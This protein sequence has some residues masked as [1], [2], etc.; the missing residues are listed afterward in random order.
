MGPVIAAGVV[1]LAM[2]GISLWGAKALPPGALLPLHHGIGGYGNWKP[3]AIG[4][5]TYPV[6][7]L[8]LGG[9]TAATATSSDPAAAILLPIAML[10]ITFGQYR[11]IQVALRE[12]RVG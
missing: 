1:V 11:A 7:G 6:V 9:I 4:L 3:K 12:K 8:F 10:A 5:I 2:V